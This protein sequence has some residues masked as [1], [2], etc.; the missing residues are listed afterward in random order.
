[1]TSRHLLVPFALIL[2]CNQSAL[3]IDPIRRSIQ[4]QDVVPPGIVSDQPGLVLAMIGTPDCPASAD[5][6]PR[7]F[8]IQA[9]PVAVKRV[10]LD[11]SKP[12][13]GIW[14]SRYPT[15]MFILFR[16]G[17]PVDFHVGIV[18][19]AN[20]SATSTN[21][22][23]FSALA[24][25]NGLIP[26]K[27]EKPEWFLSSN[28]IKSTTKSYDYKA[29]KFF[30]QIGGSYSSV[31]FRY[32]VISDVRFRKSDFRGVVFEKSIFSHVDLGGS[33]MTDEQAENIV[34]LNSICPDG[35]RS[36]PNGNTCVGH[37]RETPV[38]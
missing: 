16:D 37:G 32:T 29:L 31:T 5:F 17:K 36:G 33:A 21:E 23:I 20:P 22:Q 4:I 9:V 26:S 38:K 30:T 27:A 34:W 10:Y 8:E 35:T 28:E 24:L 11:R 12:D 15:P 3:A 1:M 7:F 18:H 13:A 6:K 14:L 25:R 19:S 2:F